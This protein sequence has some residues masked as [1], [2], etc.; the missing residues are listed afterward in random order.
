MKTP[1]S[2]TYFVR[3]LDLG[4]TVTV[5]SES[6][7]LSTCLEVSNLVTEHIRILDLLSNKDRIASRYDGLQITV[8]PL[9]S[10][11]KPPNRLY[12]S[13]LHLNTRSPCEQTPH[14]KILHPYASVDPILS[15]PHHLSAL[16]PE[17]ADYFQVRRIKK[18]KS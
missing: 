17:D 12:C 7:A 1:T 10:E 13:F 8:T 9:R 14:F 4:F 6:L 16:L 3:K 15:C 2:K 11:H 18:E 5:D